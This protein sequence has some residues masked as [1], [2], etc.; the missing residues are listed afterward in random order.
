[1]VGGRYEFLIKFIKLLSCATYLYC[2]MGYFSLLE[3]WKMVNL[4]GELYK[5]KRSSYFIIICI[6]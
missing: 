5:I 2:G 3:L 6:Y 4:I 1:M